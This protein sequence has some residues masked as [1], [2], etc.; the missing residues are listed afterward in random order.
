[1]LGIENLN[2]IKNPMHMEV[3]FLFEGENQHAIKYIQIVTDDMQQKLKHTN[4]I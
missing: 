1:M 2:K 4:V 3:T